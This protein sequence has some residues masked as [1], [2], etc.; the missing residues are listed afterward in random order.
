MEV[1][2]IASSGKHPR[3]IVELSTFT[4]IRNTNSGTW[5]KKQERSWVFVLSISG[6]EA[7]T[8]W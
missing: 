7:P 2:H 5:T 4:F 1:A 3:V 6:I 8:I